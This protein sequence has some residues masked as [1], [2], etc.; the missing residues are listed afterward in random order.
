M[1]H[2]HV[3]VE[4]VKRFLRLIDGEPGVA[5][6][7]WV[8]DY[9]G[10]VRYCDQCAERTRQGCA[11]GLPPDFKNTDPLKTTEECLSV[12]E[13]MILNPPSRSVRAMH[14]LG[15]ASCQFLYREAL[16]LSELGRM[17]YMPRERRGGVLLRA[18]F[19]IAAGYAGLILGP[20][21]AK[22]TPDA[23]V[24]AL[25]SEAVIIEGPLKDAHIK[26]NYEVKN[27]A[28]TTVPGA[29]KVNIEDLLL[30]VGDDLV[31]PVMTGSD[32]VVF[33]VSKAWDTSGS[34]VELLFLK[35]E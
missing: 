3:A 6:P 18:M 30:Q 14:F 10:R 1:S 20:G 7:Q 16:A 24:T 27:V 15:C 9:A 33:D 23:N 32:T 12:D 21:L 8:S 13:M 11:I 22:A 28:I 29:G 25:V 31:E 4:D 34:E 17:R 2:E 35:I 19:R 5:N 26:L